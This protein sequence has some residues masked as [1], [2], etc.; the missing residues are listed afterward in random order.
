VRSIKG[1][2]VTWIDVFRPTEEDIA[3]LRKIHKFHPLILDELL[4]PSA[5]SHVEH[6]DDYLFLVY[7]F[8]EYDPAGKTSRRSEID[9]LVTKDTVIT[10]R[11]ENME[12]VNVLF[13]LLS[14]NPKERDRILT[15]DTLLATYHAF[16]RAI[17]FSARQLRHIEEQVS[18]IGSRL[19]S[20][21]EE[22]LVREISEVKRNILDYRLIIHS[23]DHFFREL[24]AVGEK[25]WGM[26]SG[27][28]LTDIANDNAPIHRN[29]ENYFETI[30]SF[31]TTNGQL[32][33]AQTNHR[34]KRLSVIAFLFWIPLYFVFF[35]DFTYIHDLV[36]ATPARFWTFV[37]VIHMFPVFLW[38]IFKKKG[39]V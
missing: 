1:K 6:Y 17:S 2:K 31:E 18:L 13:D 38:A 30:E 7:Q 10:V 14:R 35:A 39:Y 19:F 36:A 8:P 37:V 27:I 9:F 12:Q 11:Y 32:L 29:L 23:Q 22:A 28:Y 24:Q 34:M 5:R 3:A 33:E 21:Q 15:G 20:G 16:E 4:H 26:K 25:F